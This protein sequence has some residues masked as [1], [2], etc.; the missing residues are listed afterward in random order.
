MGDRN[1][2]MKQIQEVEFAAIEW[3]LY[4]D[5]HRY[6]QKALME[7][8]NYSN[9]LLML[10]QQYE[11]LYGPLVNFGFSPSHCSWRWLDSPWP[12]EEEF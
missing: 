1:K 10:K 12:W 5:T 8:N 9:Q 11:M 7:Y 4:L 3:Q 6:D 2:L